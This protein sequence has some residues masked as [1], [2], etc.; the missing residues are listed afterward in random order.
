M[1]TWGTSLNFADLFKEVYTD[2]LIRDVLH[3]TMIYGEGV[4]RVTEDQRPEVIPPRMMGLSEMLDTAAQRITAS[5]GTVPDTVLLTPSLYQAI[6]SGNMMYAPVRLDNEQG[7]S[8]AGMNVISDPFVPNDS[9]YVISYNNEAANR[10]G[11][12]YGYNQSKKDKLFYCCDECS[13]GG[14][15]GK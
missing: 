3:D 10:V 12:S 9:A 5:S 8:F 6:A 4:I 15:C 13:A 1:P 7:V 14:E 11:W 2:D